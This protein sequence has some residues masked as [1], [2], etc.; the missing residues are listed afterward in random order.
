[1]SR[2]SLDPR[3]S[4]FTLIEL[5]VVIAII[6]IL[7]GLLLPAVQK[8]REAASRA[9][10][11]N[12]LK[13]L[14]LACHGYHDTFG[15]FPHPDD[16]WGNAVNAGH[17][18]FYMDLLPYVEQ[19]NQVATVAGGNQ[20]NAK[21]VKIFLC[22]SR[23]TTLVGAKDDYANCFHPTAYL[24]NGWMSILGGIWPNAAY[25]GVNL[26]A[27]S[28]GGGSST[29]LLLTHKG[30]EPQFYAGGS[31][32]DPGWA[33]IDDHWESRRCPFGARPDSNTNSTVTD[34]CT[35]IDNTGMRLWI[36][37]SHPGAYPC[38]FGDGSC[39]SLSYTM[40]NDIDGNSLMG[41]LWSWNTGLIVQTSIDH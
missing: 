32:H 20:A 19:Q 5:L 14:G 21:P 28:G 37:S 31:A 23:R 15:Q 18:T 33:T 40:S 41:K 4:A 6:A 27:V 25:K 26:T 22:P 7:I 35:S 29:V 17:H 8:V 16:M 39:R 3:R 10:C 30:L 34:G 13:Q 24:G 38:L 1:M 36:G 2:S 11:L 9:Q 12:N